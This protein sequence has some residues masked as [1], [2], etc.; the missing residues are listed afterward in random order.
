MTSNNTGTWV[1][2]VQKL[3]ATAKIIS[4]RTVITSEELN[5][6]TQTQLT[7]RRRV[8]VNILSDLSRDGWRHAKPSDYEPLER[9]LREIEA[10]LKRRPAR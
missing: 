3:A 7:N 8:I 6:R 10:Q 4:K 9:E 2:T 1:D 5:M